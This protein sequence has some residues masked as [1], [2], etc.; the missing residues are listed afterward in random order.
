MKRLMD[1]APAGAVKIAVTVGNDEI[2]VNRIGS[3]RL[4]G[5]LAR[6]PE[7][8]DLMGGKTVAPMRLIEIAADAAAAFIAAGCGYDNN[9]DAETFASE[10]AIEDQLRLVEAI[11]KAT[12]PNLVGPLIEQL[13]TRV[14]VF[15]E[16]LQNPE[17]SPAA[18]TP[19]IN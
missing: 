11:A 6:Y 14:A 13:K 9:P 16:E 17:A 4:T 12:F 15:L 10:L 8:G 19:A 3:K 18:E 1:I 2:E 5:L 7:L